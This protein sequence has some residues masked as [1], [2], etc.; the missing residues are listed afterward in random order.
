[1][2]ITV[3]IGP[4]TIKAEVTQKKINSDAVFFILFDVSMRD[5]ATE[6]MIIALLVADETIARGST[7]DHDIRGAS[8]NHA[9]NN[10]RRRR[11][12]GCGQDHDPCAGARRLCYSYKALVR[13]KCAILRKIADQ[14]ELVALDVDRTKRL[15]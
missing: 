11:E 5:H 15:R 9:I 8:D 14:H 1:M 3:L 7:H 13:R 2:I 4:A 12:I 10:I 6:L